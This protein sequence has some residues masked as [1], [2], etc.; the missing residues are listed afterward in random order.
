MSRQTTLLTSHKGVDL[1]AATALRVMRERLDGGDDLQALFRCEMHAF[2][3]AE[4]GLSMD[5]LLAAGR[6]FNPNKHHFGHFEGPTVPG[7]FSGWEKLSDKSLPAEWP[8]SVQDTDLEAP[9]EGLYDILLGGPP[10]AGCCAMD[11]IAFSR[12]QDGPLV[13]GVLWRLVLQA[14]TENVLESGER[15]AVA[16][17]RKQGLLIN[18]HMEAWLRAV[19]LER[20]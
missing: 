19:R 9:G 10:P 15:L 20:R 4:H 14:S 16:R 1:H 12:G 8:G 5:G 11:F 7:L 6:Y 17:G 13:S 3:T 18:P 2:T